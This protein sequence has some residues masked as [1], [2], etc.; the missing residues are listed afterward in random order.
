MKRLGCQSTRLNIKPVIK[1]ED[2]GDSQDEVQ[3]SGRNLYLNRNSADEA[4]K[5]RYDLIKGEDE[6]YNVLVLPYLFT[7]KNQGISAQV[8]SWCRRNKCTFV[9][10]DYHGVSAAG[11]WFNEGTVTRWKQDTIELLEKTVTGKTIIVGAAVGAWVMLRVAQERP[12][13]IAAMVGVS[14]DPDF[15]EELL[16]ANLSEEDKSVIMDKG[17]HDIKWG[18]NTYRITRNLIVDGRKNLVLGGGP[19]SLDISCPLRLLHGTMDE[20]VPISIPLRLSES[21][22]SND[23]DVLLLK[24]MRHFIDTEKEY[25]ALHRTLDDAKDAAG[26][27]E[28]DLN[29]P[30]SG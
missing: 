28:I 3:K 19:D 26:N 5:L 30:G 18:D 24:G 15:T 10:A 25:D 8:E 6:N 16:W 7:P 14:C 22:A 17:A 27:Y 2:D 20:E 12:D 29:S 1:L 23:V 9:C 4:N 21:I 13:L 11:E